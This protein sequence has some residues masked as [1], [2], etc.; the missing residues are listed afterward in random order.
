MSSKMPETLSSGEPRLRRAETLCDL[1][2][3]ADAV[4]VIAQEI[5]KTPRDAA[6]WCL[7]ARAQLG[8]ER[9]AAALQ[10]AEAAVSLEPA[11]ATPHRLASLALGALGRN[12][13]A[14]AAAE[15][16]TRCEPSAWQGY[17]RLAHSLAELRG[18][19]SEA[20]DAADRALALMPDDPGPHMA[21]GAVALAAG[22]REDAAAAFCAA[23]AVDPQYGD[24]HSQLASLERRSRG[25]VW[26]GTGPRLGMRRRRSSTA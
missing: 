10:A 15:Q 25:S 4:P 3:F 1:G 26:P 17:A 14:V 18:R 8:S 24:A 16:A 5:G 20:Q 13:E 21:S 7:M 23:L 22:R 12:E 2:R 6:A 9:A 11:N 19:L